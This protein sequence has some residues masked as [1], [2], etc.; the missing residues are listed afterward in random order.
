MFNYNQL[1]NIG[2]TPL[3]RACYNGSYEC[4][5]LLL[6]YGCDINAVDLSF[7]DRRTSL[8]KLADRCLTKKIDDCNCKFHQIIHDYLKPTPIILGKQWENDDCVY[9]KN[10]TIV[11]L[12]H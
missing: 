2:A 3:H 11:S 12:L 10:N 8:H 7:G 1:T 9:H 5:D 4:V 6:S